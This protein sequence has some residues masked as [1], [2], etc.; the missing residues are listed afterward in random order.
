[1]IIFSFYISKQ[2]LSYFYLSKRWNSTISSQGIYVCLFFFFIIIRLYTEAQHLTTISTSVCQV[3]GGSVASHKG[4]LQ[5]NKLDSHKWLCVF[6]P[7]V[8]VAD[9]STQLWTPINPVTANIALPAVGINTFHY[10]EVC[11]IIYC[12]ASASRR[13]WYQPS[14]CQGRDLP[15]RQSRRAFRHICSW[16]QCSCDVEAISERNRRSHIARFWWKSKI[17]DKRIQVEK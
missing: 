13:S 17:S 1:M 8:G 16:L 14:D 9:K 3:V 11:F 4:E 15:S 10:N 7:F 2:R 6:C 12:P 5:M